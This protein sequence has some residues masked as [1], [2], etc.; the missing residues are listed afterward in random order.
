[1]N[2]NDDVD[3]RVENESLNNANLF[4]KT[5]LASEF[6]QFDLMNSLCDAFTKSF[7]PCQYYEPAQ[8]LPLKTNE[9][10]FSFCMSTSGR[11]KKI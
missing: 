4:L 2:E 10:L 6:N 5:N 7:K 3:A 9:K 1:M 11:C 8:S